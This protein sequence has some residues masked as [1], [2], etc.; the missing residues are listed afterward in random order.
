MSGSKPA[1]EPRWLFGPREDLPSRDCKAQCCKAGINWIDPHSKL[2]EYPGGPDDQHLSGLAWGPTMSAVITNAEKVQ[3]LGLAPWAEPQPS[4][5]EK[6]TRWCPIAQQL[7]EADFV[8]GRENLVRT[9][10]WHYLD[11]NLFSFSGGNEEPGSLVHASSPV[12]E[13][14]TTPSPPQ[15][16]R[17]HREYDDSYT[18]Q[19]H[20][21]NRLTERLIRSGLGLADFTTAAEFIPH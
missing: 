14:L 9:W 5:R 6:L 17:A 4:V 13:P 15:V 18:T 7:W 19:T 20:V 11:D 21:W 12:W 3:A 1:D 2:D 10:T 8:Q 16:L